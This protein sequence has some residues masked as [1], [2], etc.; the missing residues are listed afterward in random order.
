MSNPCFELW[1]ILHLKKI[2]DYSKTEIE[3]I[4]TNPRV[5]NKTFL[6]KEL[7][8]ILNSINTTSERIEELV[9]L[10]PDAVNNAIEIDI[11]LTTRWPEAPGTRVYRFI[12]NLTES[13]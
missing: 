9:K 1:L 4:K 11:D 10:Y 12:Q 6:K 3:K 8:T 13:L 7:S 5:N 2:S